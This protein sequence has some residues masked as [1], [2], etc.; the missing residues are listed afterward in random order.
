[1]RKKL[2][3]NTYTALFLLASLTAALLAMRADILSP[4][5]P[6]GSSQSASP[7]SQ[8]EGSVS[9]PP[10]EEPTRLQESDTPSPDGAVRLNYVK[11]SNFTSVLVADSRGNSEYP[12]GERDTGQKV[13]GLDV[14]TTGWRAMLITTPAAET[15]TITFGPGE[16]G[17]GTLSWAVGE[18]NWRPDAAMRY[19]DL[20]LPKG[21]TA[22]LRL[23]PQGAEPLRL[24][25]GGDGTFED[26]L[27]PAAF[28][29]GAAARDTEGPTI[30]FGETRRGSKTLVTVRAVD[31]S[32]IAS[33]PNGVESIFYSLEPES[34]KMNFQLY[35][36]PLELDASS[37]HGIF[38]F[39]DDKAGNRSGNSYS[40]KGP[41]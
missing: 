2:T 33:E 7:S 3:P 13:K 17:S 23:T 6:A 30:C 10:C 29:T 27:E 5:G 9:E 31:S 21:S 41:E 32:G 37:R 19:K 28:V 14:E 8:T 24:D 15:F 40:L 18:D 36:G 12:Y 22:M 20:L 4:G 11:L 34:R 35:T 26:T 38:V 39:A 1:M 25:R 16:E